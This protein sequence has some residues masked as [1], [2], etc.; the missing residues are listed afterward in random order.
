MAY[1]RAM[2]QHAKDCVEA[3]L[4]GEREPTRDFG[5]PPKLASY[6]IDR[7]GNVTKRARRDTKG[8]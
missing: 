2:K 8:G 5:Q 4:A 3:A 6:E 1:N 7:D